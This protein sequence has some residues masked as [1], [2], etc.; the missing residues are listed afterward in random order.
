MSERIVIVGGGV[1]G[2]LLANLLSKQ[3]SA[4]RQA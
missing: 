4:D 2:T 1:G 3:L